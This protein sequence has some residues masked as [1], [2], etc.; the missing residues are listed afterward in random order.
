MPERTTFKHVLALPSHFLDIMQ[1]ASDDYDVYLQTFLTTF[2][3]QFSRQ[4]FTVYWMD[5]QMSNM[6]YWMFNKE[7]EKKQV[8]H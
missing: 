6:F 7:I 8:Y 3:P 5:C 2:H 1:E 4:T